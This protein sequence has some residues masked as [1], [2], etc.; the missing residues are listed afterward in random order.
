MFTCILSLIIWHV[1]Y[2]RR[3]KIFY[4]LNLSYGSS[5]RSP[6]RDFCHNNKYLK[7]NLSYKVWIISISFLFLIPLILPSNI[8]FLT[9]KKLF[10]SYARVFFF[11]YDV[12]EKEHINRI[13]LFL[14]LVSY[15]AE[16]IIFPTL[17]LLIFFFSFL[18]LANYL[19]KQKNMVKSACIWRDNILKHFVIHEKTHKI[20]NLHENL[21]SFPIFLQLILMSVVGFTGIALDFELDHLYHT[22]FLEG[23]SYLCFSTLGIASVTYAASKVSLEQE[24]IS[25]FYRRMIGR[26]DIQLTLP[27]LKKLAL[28][29]AIYERP[30]VY[31][32][33]WKITH[34]DRK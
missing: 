31:L 27:I 12:S 21:F 22:H 7:H 28:L 8:A 26:N 17:F 14:C 29:K 3:Y 32:T 4:V 23:M 24:E 2:Y 10:Y 11:V 33:A 18:K 13:V 1:V 34:L 25:K 5:A 6:I 15:F 9:Q 16:L 20:I 19:D 30:V